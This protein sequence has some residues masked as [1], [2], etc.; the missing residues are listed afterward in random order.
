MNVYFII[1]D[2]ITSKNHLKIQNCSKKTTFKQV[3]KKFI[4]IEWNAQIKKKKV[5]KC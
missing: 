1:H 2:F 4:K 5:F 3:K